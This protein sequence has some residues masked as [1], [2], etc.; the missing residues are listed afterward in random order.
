MDADGSVAY[1]NPAHQERVITE[2]VA[3][4][5]VSMLEDVVDRGTGA[6][7]R[8]SYGVR[9]P[10]GGK[11][12]TTDDF[13]DAWFVGFTSSAVVGVWV[14][15]DQPATIGREGYGARYALP[16]WSEFIKTAARKRG[17]R[18]FAAPGGLRDEILCKVSYL[19]PVEGCPTYTEYFKDGDQIPSRL[20]P[21]HK[22]SVKQQLKRAVQGFFS[23]LGRKLKGIFR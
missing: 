17:A 21:I 2:Q 6:P 3:Y 15:A 1:D 22:G 20:C 9:F 16:I 14:G 18:E 11:T 13:K 5:M 19:K 12:G 8:N 7:A 4:Q 23:G 10:V